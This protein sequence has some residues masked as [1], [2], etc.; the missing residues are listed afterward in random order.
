M[1]AGATQ[2]CQNPRNLVPEAAVLKS[3]HAIACSRTL[4]VAIVRPEKFQFLKKN[5]KIVISITKL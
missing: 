2:L 5:G 1:G 4:W 3:S